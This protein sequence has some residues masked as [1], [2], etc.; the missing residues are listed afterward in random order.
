MKIEVN[1]T[2]TNKGANSLI[3]DGFR[4]RVDKA[5][6]SKEISWRCTAKSCTAR[7]RTD[8]NGSMIVQ[9]KNTHNHDAN[10]RE[11][12]R[13]VLRVRAKRKADDYISQRPSKI[14]RG[15]LK[16]V[17]EEY[18]QTSIDEVVPTSLVSL[19]EQYCSEQIL[20]AHFVKTLG[21]QHQARTDLSM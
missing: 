18:L 19:Y 1:L 15:E 7:V 13:H 2:E 4:F 11:N 14:I 16:T 12:E 6:K 17:T 21:F 3:C 20:T 9:Q 8:E 10:D 5:L